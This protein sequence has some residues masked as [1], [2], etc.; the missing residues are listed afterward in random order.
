ML[1]LSFKDHNKADVMTARKMTEWI[2]RTFK[3]RKQSSMATLFK[4]L[5]LSRV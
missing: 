1:F 3:T 2:E 4:S 5:V